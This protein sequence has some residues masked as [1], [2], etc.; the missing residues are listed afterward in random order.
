MAGRAIEADEGLRTVLHPDGRPLAE[1]DRL[2][3]PALAGTLRTLAA[4]GPRALYE[5]TL[6]ARLVA[7]LSAAGCPLR[8]L[9]FERFAPEEGPPLRGRFADLTVL[10]APPNSA[11]V[12]LLQALAAIQAAG[13]GMAALSGDAG[14]VAEVLRLGMR[15]RDRELADPAFE[16]FDPGAWLGAQRI[17]ELVDLARAAAAGRRRE[18]APT[19]GRED[20]DTVAVVTADDAG[21][22]VS[23]IQSLAS[24]FGAA[25]L[26][27]ETGILMHSRGAAFALETGHPNVLAPG[28]RPAHT[29]MPVIAERGGELFSVQGTMGGRAHAQIHVQVL[30][31][32]LAGASPGE[33]VAAPRFIVGGVTPGPGDTV[34]VEEGVPAEARR[35][36]E[37]ARMRLRDLPASSEATGHAQ[38][39]APDASGILRAGTDPRA[40]G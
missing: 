18:P 34:W 30:L 35:A 3:Q 39:V 8:A 37:R 4:E 24:S 17:A 2:R 26:E 19:A 14:L 10:T 38:V 31:R 29:L 20:G 15:Q 23:L 6:T 7:G 32:L 22:A 21:R 13:V 12:L 40:D 27:P 28:K 9:D 36:F 1:G 25:I 5:G 16:R 33:A 11:G